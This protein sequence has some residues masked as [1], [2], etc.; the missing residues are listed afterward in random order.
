MIVK[1]SREPRR[2]QKTKHYYPS[3][4]QTEDKRLGSYSSKFTRNALMALRDSGTVLIYT[5]QS[6]AGCEMKHGR[7]F[8]LRG[9]TN[10]KDGITA[11]T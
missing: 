10:E 7:T 6:I 11:F 3:L 9:T 8:R 1:Q 2:K 5:E 4:F